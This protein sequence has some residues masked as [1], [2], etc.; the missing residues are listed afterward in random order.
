MS[1]IERA[2]EKR[3]RS[4]G[5]AGVEPPALASL[6]AGVGTE[7]PVAQ[8]GVADRPSP[9]PA[10]PDVTLDFAWLRRQGVMVPGEQ[11][12]GL[13]EEFRILKRPLLDNAFG[14]AGEPMVDKGRLIMVTSAVPG[15]GKTFC[16]M[17]LALSMALEVDRTVLLVDAD[18]ARPS[19]P[20]C[21]GIQADRGL[22]DVL[23]EPGVGLGDVLLRTQVPNLTILPAGRP[24]GRSTE[25]LAGQ[26]ML[27]LLDELYHRYPD[28]VILFDSP[29]LIA[30]SEPSVLARSM[31]QILLVVEAEHTPRVAV[32][33]AAEL[34]AGCDVV[35]TMM[36]KASPT[37]GAG[38]GGYYGGYAAAG[39]S[40]PRGR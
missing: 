32:A 13:A 17:N 40:D 33:R 9:A 24:H 7:E 22:M 15:E 38:Y 29:P 35:L 18:V 31:G 28:R 23:T 19:L 20:R 36:N 26:G 5:G 39:G 37:P 4:H 6:H 3:R 12:S 14:R 10:N 34:L 8:S 30:T 25:L 27:D 11:R 16:T 21:L 1:I 2:L